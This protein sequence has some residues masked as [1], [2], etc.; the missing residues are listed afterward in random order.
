MD[1]EFKKLVIW[2]RKGLGAFLLYWTVELF[3]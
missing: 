1:R 2:C 3:G